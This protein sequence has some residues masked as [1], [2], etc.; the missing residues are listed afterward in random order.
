MTKST[1]IMKIV[2]WLVHQPILAQHIANGA[3]RG[4][5]PWAVAEQAEHLLAEHNEQI[6]LKE[7]SA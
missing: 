6:K 7:V 1:E 4:L 2:E 3:A 5:Y